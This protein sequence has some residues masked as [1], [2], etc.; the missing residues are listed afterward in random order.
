MKKYGFSGEI[1]TFVQDGTT[2]NIRPEGVEFYDKVLL[3][4]ECSLDASFKHLTKYLGSEI[5]NGKNKKSKVKK[6][7]DHLSKKERKRRM[8]MI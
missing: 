5:P 6:S 2:F 7:Y 4:A 1:R 8:K 3:D